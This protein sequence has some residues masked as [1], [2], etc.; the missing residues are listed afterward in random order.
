M[1]DIVFDIRRISPHGAFREEQRA[2][3]QAADANDYN[4]PA[5]TPLQHNEYDAEIYYGV[6]VTNWL[7]VRP[8]LQ[9]IK[10]PGGVREVDNA[11][12]GGLKVQAVF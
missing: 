7:T 6:H 4:D 8:N 3:N 5:F 2:L 12:V 10:N 11:V 1:D 9:Y